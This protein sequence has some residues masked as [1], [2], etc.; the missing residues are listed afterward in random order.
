VKR[1]SPTVPTG[2]QSPADVLEARRRAWDDRPLT[3]EVYRRYFESILAE[4]AP[5]PRTLEIGGGAGN[6]KSFA[7][8]ILVSDLVSTP[9]VDLV[10]DALRLPVPDATLDNLIL[11]DVL[12]HLPRPAS[13]FDEAQRALRPGGRLIMLEPYISPASRLVFKLAHPEPINVRVDPLPPHDAP[14]FDA[15]GPFSSNQA[16]PTLLFFRHLQRFAARWPAFRLIT[17]RRDSVFVYP[18]TGGFS[19]PCLIPHCAAPLAWAVE[20]LLTPLAPLLAFRLLVVLE[21]I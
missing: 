16:I 18:L 1:R 2:D 20:R 10:A 9:Y 17:R 5:G 12:H 14:L 8:H 3:R 11:V 4:C 21:K 13:F 6:L 7:P 19:G 15:A